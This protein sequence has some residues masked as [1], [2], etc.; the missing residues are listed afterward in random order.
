MKPTCPKCASEQLDQSTT[1][2][3]LCHDCSRFWTLVLSWTVG[4]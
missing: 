4:T 3:I 1:G 2:K